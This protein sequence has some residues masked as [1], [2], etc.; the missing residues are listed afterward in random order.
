M[1]LMNTTPMRIVFSVLIAAAFA[2]VP[3]LHAQIRGE[4]KALETLMD[5][6]ETYEKDGYEFRQQ[7]WVGILKPELGRAVRVQFFKGLEYKVCI[8]V[9]QDSG[10]KV[11]AVLLDGEGKQ[12]G[13]ADPSEGAGN[14]VISAKPR[15]TGYYAVAIRLV[16][17]KK[18]V[19]CA[20]TQG[21]K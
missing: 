7:A 6:V 17:G 1:A 5:S 12:V 15:R 4:N 16:E 8:S 14:V 19:V 3:E 2:V 18:D 13:Q 11:A 20:M 9:P 10:A 21:W